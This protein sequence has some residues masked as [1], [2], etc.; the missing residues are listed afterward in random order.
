MPDFVQPRAAWR[1]TLGGED[2]TDR[3][4]PRLVS[5]RLSEKRGESAD[6]LEITLQDHDGQLALPPEG[7]VLT[8]A[9]GWERGT[10]VDVGLVSKGS[11]KVQDITWSGPPDLVTIT[12]RSADLK[13]SF[14]TRTSK[15]W[16]DTTLGNIISKIAGAHGLAARCHGQ[17]TGKSVTVAEQ[18]NKSDMQF[19]RDLGRRYDAVA[20]VKDGCLIFAPVGAATTS[21]GKTIPGI[22]LTRQS[23]DRVT[24]RRAAR[25]GGQD[26]AEAQWHDQDQAQRKKATKGG[27][28]RRRLKRVYASETDAK[29]AATSETNRLKRAAASLDVTLALG[30]ALA[31]P[32]GRVTAVG[33]KSEIDAQMWLVTEVSHEM[34]GTGGYRTS[35]KMEV[36]A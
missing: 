26:G 2:L 8:V 33:F 4:K 31:A 32:G 5:L 11:F 17:L 1:V 14:R 19:L 34:D 10:F 25:E 12:A 28:N 13:E 24:Y 7:A 16:K 30:N 3:M 35:L 29:A 18:H 27:S 23:G 9:L 15:V 36:A 21:T 22:A 6:S 20:T